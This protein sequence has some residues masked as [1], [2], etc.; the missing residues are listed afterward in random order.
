MSTSLDW[1]ASYAIALA[2]KRRFPDAELEEVSLEMIYKW[3]L[4]LP[5]FE[6]DP[7]LANDAILADIYREWCELIF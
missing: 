5:E 1:D 3:S 4:Q 6:D 7:E 2:L